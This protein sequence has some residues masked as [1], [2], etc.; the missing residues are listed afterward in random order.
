ME[1]ILTLIACFGALAIDQNWAYVVAYG[2]SF[3]SCTSIIWRAHRLK[4]GV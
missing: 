2:V 4:R 3:G 1:I